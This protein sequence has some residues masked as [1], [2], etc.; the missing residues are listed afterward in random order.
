MTPEHISVCKF[1]GGPSD[2]QLMEVPDDVEVMTNTY[3]V[4]MTGDGIKGDEEFCLDDM[5]PIFQSAK[6]LR[7]GL[8]EFRYQR[9]E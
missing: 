6:Y 9:D 4:P 7:S 2:G 3:P 8:R 1:I 5:I